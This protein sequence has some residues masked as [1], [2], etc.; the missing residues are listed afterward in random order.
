MRIKKTKLICFGGGTGMPSLLTGLK[1]NPWI[2]VRAVVNMFDNGG[3]SG[4]LR[5]RFGI[6]PP[7]GYLKMYF[8]FIGK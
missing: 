8:S 4:E 1:Q 2:E 6:L 7:G 3:S 5:D